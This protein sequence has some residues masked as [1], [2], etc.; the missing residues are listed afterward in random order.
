MIREPQKPLRE[1]ITKGPWKVSNCC[2]VR[3]AAEKKWQHE[4]IIA[5]ENDEAFSPTIATVS[6]KEYRNTEKEAHGADPEALANAQ[7]LALAPQ[8]L[9]AL[10]DFR[11]AYTRWNAREEGSED[12][13]HAAG[14]KAIAIVG[15]SEKPSCPHCKGTDLEE[16]GYCHDCC[17]IVF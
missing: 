5:M 14:K 4:P 12:D 11:D 1:R 3:E 2:F 10:E 13:M 9:E 6:A 15:E 8:M 7:L 17:V 16:D